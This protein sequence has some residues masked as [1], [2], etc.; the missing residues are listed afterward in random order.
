MKYP[1]N[2]LFFLQ[3]P[4][5]FFVTVNLEASVA[6]KLPIQP[7]LNLTGNDP[8][9]LSYAQLNNYNSTMLPASFVLTLNK[10]MA[11]CTDLIA[12]ITKLT[13][14]NF[15][16]DDHKPAPIL[17]LIGKQASNGEIINSSKGLLV[18]LPDQNHC[19]FMSENRS[20]NGVVA[21]SIPFTDTAHVSRI[22]QL[23]RQQALFN[24][25]ISSCVRHNNRS[26]EFLYRFSAFQRFIQCFCLL[27]QKLS[28]NN[29]SGRKFSFYLVQR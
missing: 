15:N 27:N 3:F 25:L 1:F 21:K 8:Q 28:R 29:E 24:T 12:Q 17:S 11:V 22:V 10:P 2:F 26:G 18:T 19:Y 23:L 16:S 4:G 7:I 5:A 14:L 20:M 9:N 6:H 13:E